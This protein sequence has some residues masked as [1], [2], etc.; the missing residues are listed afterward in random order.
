VGPS[1]CPYWA[2]RGLPAAYGGGAG[3]W[4]NDLQHGFDGPQWDACGG[5]HLGRESP[6]EMLIGLIAQ[7]EDVLARDKV[8]GRGTIM[9]TDVLHP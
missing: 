9:H 6:E 7:A 3:P 5:T 4:Q 1:A 2:P 8:R